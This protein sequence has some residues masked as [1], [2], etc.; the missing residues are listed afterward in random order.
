MERFTKVLYW[1]IT[2]G[3]LVNF[4]IAGM[5]LVQSRAADQWDAVMLVNL[6]VMA[7]LVLVRVG[8]GIVRRVQSVKR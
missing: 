4:C 7:I 1:L 8:Y 6:G 5:S 3:V 2:V